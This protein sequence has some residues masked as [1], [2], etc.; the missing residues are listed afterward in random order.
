MPVLR[1]KYVLAGF[2]ADAPDPAIPALTHIGEQ[3]FAKNAAVAAHQHPVWEFYF[4]I[5]GI[6]R[7]EVA[8][9]PLSLDSGSL[10]AVAPGTTHGL[11]GTAA[12]PHHFFFAGIDIGSVLSDTKEAAMR[13]RKTRPFFIRHAPEAAPAFRQL[14]REVTM[15]SPFR[16]EMLQLALRFLALELTRI[17][18]SETGE[19][20]SLM[21]RHPAVLRARELIDH[22]P[23]RTWTLRSLAV[24]AGLSPSRLSACFREEIGMTPHQYLMRARIEAARELLHDTDRQVTDIALDLGFASSQHFSSAFRSL[25]GQ[26]PSASRRTGKQ[27]IRSRITRKKRSK[28][29]AT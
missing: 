9:R 14:V 2:H 29:P 23:G 11:D 6:T 3:W 25:T 20:D 16:T 26:C 5:E 28:K 1:P 17:L 19:G 15:N 7:W 10:L 21:L 22:Q 13:W 12:T 8:G 24:M 18:R 4:Q 27:D